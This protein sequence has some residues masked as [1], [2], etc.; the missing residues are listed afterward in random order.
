MAEATARKP[1]K[2]RDPNAPPRKRKAIDFAATFDLVG[3]DGNP[4]EVP[5]GS[6]LVVKTA[7]RDVLAV[8]REGITSGGLYAEFQLPA[9]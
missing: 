1:R 4:V 8:L 9:A 2:P 5:A 7:T 3:A 6:K